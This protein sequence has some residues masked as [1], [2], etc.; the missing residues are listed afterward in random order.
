MC[1]ISQKINHVVAEAGN[2]TKSWS[3]KLRHI[4][5]IWTIHLQIGKEIMKYQTMMNGE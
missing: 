5:K 1:L 4:P 2:T 3:E